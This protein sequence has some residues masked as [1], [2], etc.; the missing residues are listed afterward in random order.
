MVRF[1]KKIERVVLVSDDKIVIPNS[2]GIVYYPDGTHLFMNYKDLTDMLHKYTKYFSFESR[3]LEVKSIL[4]SELAKEEAFLSSEM[5]EFI[6]SDDLEK[7]EK[8]RL[9]EKKLDLNLGLLI[10]LYAYHAVKRTKGNSLVLDE[11]DEVIDRALKIATL[12]CEKSGIDFEE[13]S[14]VIISHILGIIADSKKDDKDFCDISFCTSQDSVFNKYQ[15][16]AK[17][18]INGSDFAALEEKYKQIRFDSLAA[19]TASFQGGS[20]DFLI[21]I[22]DE[23]YPN[24]DSILKN[25]AEYLTV[26][27][28]YYEIMDAVNVCSNL[29]RLQKEDWQSLNFDGNNIRRKENASAVLEYDSQDELYYIRPKNVPGEKEQSSY[30]AVM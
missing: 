10:N 25:W 30:T 29:A 6:K 8:A 15:E 20:N 16:E 17:E 23:N 22:F 1:M 7:A 19:Y 12:E 27:H 18:A 21:S 11:V 28:D 24:R 5:D 13:K 3:N 14:D 26:C 2:Y 4:R 9:I